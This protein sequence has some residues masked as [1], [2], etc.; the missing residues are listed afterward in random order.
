MTDIPKIV[1]FDLDDTLSKSK[2]PATKEMGQIFAQLLS[3]T[4]AG[5][6]SGA[7][8]EQIESQF[9]ASLPEGAN[10]DNLYCFSQNAASCYARKDGVFTQLYSFTFSDNEAA[11]IMSEIEQVLNETH[12]LDNEPSF[13]PRIENRGSQIT[14]SALGQ[15]APGDLKKL[16]DPQQEKRKILRNLLV[17]RLHN[18]DIGIGGGTSVDITKKG[19]NKTYAVYWTKDNL[20]IPIENMAYIG[21]ALFEG[22]NDAVVIQTGIT[23]IA[24]TGPDETIT[25]IKKLLAL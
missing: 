19:I 24:T 4:K 1:L 22:G 21:D 16:F 17:T 6:V 8:F 20:N 7:R 14:L 5:I 3:V 25:I 15:Q 11:D 2:E 12:M 13:G 23:T 18:V 9:I 10:L